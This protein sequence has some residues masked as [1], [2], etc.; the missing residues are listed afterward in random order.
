MAEEAKV[1]DAEAEKAAK[2]LKD[3]AS[4][5][6]EEFVPPTDGSWVP[7]ARL[8]QVLGSVDRL[9]AELAASREQSNTSQPLSSHELSEAVLNGDLTQ[10][11]A[12]AQRESAIEAR[13]TAKM[14]EAATVNAMAAKQQVELDR[15]IEA[16]PELNVEGSPLHNKLAAEYRHSVD[17]L[18]LPENNG[19][20]VAAIRTVAGPLSTIQA[21]GKLT[22][23]VEPSPETGGGSGGE[24]EDKTKM[25][26]RQKAF[27][28]NAVRS[29]AYPDMTA[30][31]KELE[32]YNAR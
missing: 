19:T 2:A 31:E 17:D 8:D 10:D 21:T 23:K 20:L 27:G 13:V 12:D 5:A 11:E 18:G 25:T 26:P 32:E 28:E 1:D 14:T 7:K 4:H 6:E 24:G 16:L 29:G 30:Y 3:K 15:Y 9:T 22:R